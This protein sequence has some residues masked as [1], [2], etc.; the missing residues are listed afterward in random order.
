[1]DGG[2]PIKAPVAGIAMG[3]MLSEAKPRGIEG[4]EIPYPSLKLRVKIL[5]TKF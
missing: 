4:S 3:L 2:V 1:M 5:S